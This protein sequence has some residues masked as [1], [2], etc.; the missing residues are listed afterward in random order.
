MPICQR[1]QSGKIRDCA[2][3]SE[4]RHTDGNPEVVTKLLP[5]GTPPY[6]L[7]LQN[8]QNQQLTTFLSAKY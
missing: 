7:F 1:S 8:I 2:T 6:P 5:E 3:L 4:T